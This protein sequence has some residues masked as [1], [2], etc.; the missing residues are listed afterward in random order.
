MHQREL[1]DL[2]LMTLIRKVDSHKGSHGS[3]AVIG[4]NVGMLG[5]ALLCGRAAL[6][7]G[8]GKVWIDALDDRLAVDPF[9]PE[10][11]IR[12]ADTDLHEASALAVG[13]GMGQDPLAHAALER[14]F[15][16]SNKPSVFDADALNMIAV[17]DEFRLKIA[18]R[19]L[20]AILTPHPAEAG[21]L[22]GCSAEEVQKDR[23]DAAKQIAVQYN[24]IT[25]LKGHHTV[26]M[27]PNGGYLINRTGGPE[28]AVAGQGDILSGVIS[29]LLAQ[30]FSAFDAAS[31]AAHIHGLAGNLYT[32]KMN[33]S[34]GL[35]ASMT[36]ALVSQMLNQLLVDKSKQV[37]SKRILH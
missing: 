36:V 7:A 17:N 18:S 2:A 10:L 28:L 29:A 13:M 24:S 27:H 19:E 26:I 8:T 33:G 30:G 20:K 5:A 4:G 37:L 12:S 14:I 3:V 16:Y 22:L 15:T 35:T 25:L 1:N 9:A 11:M 31:W 21:R 34:I 23:L 6:A 32:K